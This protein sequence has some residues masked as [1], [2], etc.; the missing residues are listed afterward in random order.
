MGNKWAA[1]CRSSRFLLKN[2]RNVNRRR[3]YCK[4]LFLK[5]PGLLALAL[6]MTGCVPKPD[7]D[8]ITRGHAL[9]N[10]ALHGDLARLKTLLA[11]G[12]E[13][14]ARDHN[15]WT[16]LHWASDETAR[17]GDLRN[18]QA[19]LRLLIAHG[20]DVNARTNHGETPLGFG[21]WSDNC[22]RVLLEA[23]ANVNIMG[24]FMGGAP[25]HEAAWQGSDEGVRLLLHAGANPNAQTSDGWTPLMFA[26]IHRSPQCVED[27]LKAGA[28]V[29]TR[30]VLGETALDELKGANLP[31]AFS[32][33]I[34]K[35]DRQ[36]VR[37]RREIIAKLSAAND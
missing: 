4:E 29:N 23:G 28:R 32:Q 13:V 20:A 24:A 21:A 16:A 5:S 36:Y 15:G 18:Q 31:N 17:W 14:N 26:V 22:I 2:Q 8:Y 37:E 6:I 1:S 35:S 10:A 25:L 30:N 12:L 19:S 9:N 11:S 7:L 3:P 34:L 27:L 33:M